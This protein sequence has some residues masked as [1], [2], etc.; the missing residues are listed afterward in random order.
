[1]FQDIAPHRISYDPG[2]H[3]PA[4]SDHV[5]FLKQG[6]VLLKLGDAA[7]V[8]PTYD[9]ARGLLAGKTPDSVYL[10]SVDDVAYYACPE[11]P[12]ESGPFAYGPMRLLREVKP[13]FAA[14]A[15]AT[16]FHF[17]HW[18][19]VNRYCGSCGGPMA[20]KD[21]ERA[22]CCP[23]CGMVKYPRISPVVIVGITRG[24]DLLLAKNATGEYRDYGLIAGFVEPGE[25]LEAAAAREVMEE[26]GL[27]VTNLRYYKS[28]P[29]AFS[30]SLLMGFF[31][32]LDGQGEVTL[33][34]RELAEARWFERME[35][36]MNDA[37]RFSLT[38]DMIHA[39]R[40]RQV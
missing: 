5:F 30:Q 33:D 17:A 15:G 9:D 14:F 38:W 35:L 4:G 27:K 1:M 36:P 21:D 39:F 20:A 10:F 29:W 34:G 28:Q 31:G 7:P 37:I 8:V 32:D 19:G 25:T 12:E 22:L 6:R 11:Q 3:A 24:E 23:G 18:Y 40:E 2:H 13:D 26:V 16:A